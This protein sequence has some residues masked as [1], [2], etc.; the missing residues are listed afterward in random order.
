[1]TG[2]PELSLFFSTDVKDTDFFATLSDVYPDGRSIL[3]TVGA[4]RT[5]YRDSILKTSLLTPNQ[6][7][8]VKISLWETSNLFKTGH[9]IRLQIASSNFPRFN[10]N[11]NSGKAMADESEDDI[12]VAHQVILHDSEHPSSL[13]LPVIPR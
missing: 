12:R 8:Q 13:S 2:T 3:I 5:R 9:R 4:L 1:V 11:L 10:R 7:Y 6:P